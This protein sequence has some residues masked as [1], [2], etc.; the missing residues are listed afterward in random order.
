M[1]VG[2][3]SL[4][5]LLLLDVL[6]L[7]V[8]GTAIEAR[9][10]HAASTGNVQTIVAIGDSIVYGLHDEQHL[11]GWVGRLSVMLDHTYPG[12]HFVALNEGLNGDTSSGVLKRLQHDVITRNPSL[13][14][15]AI[16]TND[17]DTSVPVDTFRTN[18]RTILW[19]V[20]HETHAAIL[21]QS[22]LPE[23]RVPDDVLDREAAYNAVVPQVCR[24]IGVG[25]LDLFNTF[26][27]LGRIAMTNLRHDTEHPNAAGYRFIAAT[28]SAVLESAYINGQGLISRPRQA[29][30][31]DTL[32]PDDSLSRART[33]SR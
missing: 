23:V 26:L 24:Q 27:A 28:T 16:G 8:A 11:G 6:L 30:G 32:L 20:Q 2:R 25:Y 17:F 12:R 14:I 10:G 31:I 13:V 19:E 7:G 15:V 29:A 4:V 33:S 21:V 1:K 3:R 9:T 18:L 22:L 5:Y